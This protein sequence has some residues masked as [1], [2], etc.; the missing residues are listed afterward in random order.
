MA[1]SGWMSVLLPQAFHHGISWLSSADMSKMYTIS[2]D[3]YILRPSLQLYPPAPQQIMLKVP[4]LQFLISSYKSRPFLT[5]KSKGHPR[6]SNTV[7]VLACLQP[8]LANRVLGRVILR[9]S[10][11]WEVLDE[12]VVV[13]QQR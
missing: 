3:L 2:T 13:M 12:I 7:S 11:A 9:H 1:D 5:A 10:S 4:R 8:T 6:V